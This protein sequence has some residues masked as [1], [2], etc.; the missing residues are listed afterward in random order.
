M[1][2]ALWQYSGESSEAENLY[3]MWTLPCFDMEG[4]RLRI[5][6]H[7]VPCKLCVLAAHHA[8]L[9]MC[10]SECCTMTWAGA[11]EI[12][13]KLRKAR[14]EQHSCFEMRLSFVFYSSSTTSTADCDYAWRSSWSE[15]VLFCRYTCCNNDCPCSGR[16]NEQVCWPMLFSFPL[17]CNEGSVIF[18]CLWHSVTAKCS[19]NEC[20][21]AC[22]E[23][24]LALEVSRLCLGL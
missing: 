10:G 23:V 24:C 12:L 3:C 1:Q 16:M 7:R 8:S 19:P 15:Q 11:A 14:N 22:P 2:I 4:S 21:Q 9:T 5:M 17:L 6:S 20:L 18:I 13:V